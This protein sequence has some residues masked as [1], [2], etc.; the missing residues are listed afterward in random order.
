[1]VDGRV[2]FTGG[3]NIGDEY[4]GKVPRFGFWRDTHLRVEGPAVAGLQRVFVEGWDF[5]AEEDLRGPEFFPP[6]KSEGSSGRV[7]SG[8]PSLATSHH[9]PLT[10]HH[11][12]LDNCTL[13]VIPSGPDMELKSI[14]EVYFAAVIR[15][16]QR[17]WIASPYFVPDAGLR[18]ALCLAGYL[19]IDVRLLCQHHPDKWIPFFASRYYWSDVLAAGVKVYQ[20]TKGMMH[21]KVVLVDGEWASVGT[22]NLDNRSLHLNFEVNCLIYSPEAVEEL[23]AAFRRD[24]ADSVLLDPKVYARRPLPGRLVENACRL[25]SPVL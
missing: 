6:L 10:T 19:G 17:L 1:V 16:Q 5:A 7:V 13:Q 23:E 9:S 12:L 4:L 22:A 3:L 25:L 24:L 21:S 18:D 11:P 2:A 14:R 20:Y 15:A 8:A